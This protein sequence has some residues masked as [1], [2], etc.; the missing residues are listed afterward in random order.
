MINR[1]INETA[2]ELKLTVDDNASNPYTFNFPKIKINSA[3][4]GVDGPGQRLI[5]LS[6]VA[7]YDDTEGTN[8]I[9]TR[10]V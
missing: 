3:D 4:T 1:F 7:L 10:T 2:S 6:F 9:V 5:T 8:F